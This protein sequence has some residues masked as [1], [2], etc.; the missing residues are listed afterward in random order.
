MIRAVWL[1]WSFLLIAFTGSF[2][3]YG[4][5]PLP[6]DKP[7]EPKDFATEHS[8]PLDQPPKRPVA[9]FNSIKEYICSFNALMQVLWILEPL[10]TA[11][12]EVKQA[13]SI[14]KTYLASIDAKNK[15][16]GPLSLQPFIKKINA[17]AKEK[18][19]SP[20]DILNNFLSPLSGNAYTF[21]L[22]NYSQRTYCDNKKKLIH[23]SE[24]LDAPAQPKYLTIHVAKNSTNLQKALTSVQELDVKCTCG[25]KLR[26]SLTLLDQN[27]PMI[28]A[29]NTDRQGEGMN[30]VLYPY[31]FPLFNL[32][33]GN[34]LYDLV[35]VI[36]HTGET[37]NA[38]H[39]YAWVEYNGTWYKCN[40]EKIQSFAEMKKES[41]EKQFE[42]G[43]YFNFTV[44]LTQTSLLVY[45][46]KPVI[47]QIRIA[48]SKTF[49]K[50]VQKSQRL[51]AHNVWKQKEPNIDKFVK[52]INPIIKT[53]PDLIEKNFKKQ[54]EPV[55]QGMLN[56]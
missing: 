21:F 25:K 15:F 33:F 49:R 29:V 8:M 3:S 34:K 11:L 40:D 2:K 22:V 50:E 32:K 53:L 20:T 24:S 47:Q 5:L 17:L 14:L 12:K 13:D 45:I 18:L 1:R 52:D 35:G 6:E 37:I 10:N 51:V 55:F 16:G 19:V 28:L 36:F 46:E 30:K 39:Y 54:W 41:K 44:P 48:R 42:A 26:R 9:L 23:T 56:A 31:T 43:D 7:A 38:G 4:A 27:P